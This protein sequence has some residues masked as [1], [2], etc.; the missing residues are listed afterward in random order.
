MYLGDSVKAIAMGYAERKYDGYTFDN[1]IKEYVIQ[2][3][4]I[5]RGETNPSYSI[6]PEYPI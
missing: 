6:M 5:G 2:D 1:L 3:S 4:A